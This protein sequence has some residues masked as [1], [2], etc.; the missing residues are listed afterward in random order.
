MARLD[1]DKEKKQRRD[2]LKQ[3]SEMLAEMKRSLMKEMQGR[4]KGE[5]EGS[6]DEGLSLIHISEPTRH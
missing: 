4:V 6:K 5:T 3:A 2:F 1:V